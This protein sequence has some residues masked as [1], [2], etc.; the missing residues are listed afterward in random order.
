MT[1]LREEEFAKRVT[2]HLDAGTADLRQGTAYR[3]QLARQAALARLAETETAT[4]G[5]HGGGGLLRLGGPRS[6][7]GD[8]RFWVSVGVL[9]AALVSYYQWTEY[10]N[11]RE[12]EE[13]D[14]ALLA[15]DLPIEAYL[16]K[17]FHN[18]L[19]HSE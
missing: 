12:L 13:M 1:D 5:D 2:Q 14:A 7:V 4:A 17:G 11:L 16:D 18:W 9:M 3:L 10:Q 19:K 6:R 15:S 8:W